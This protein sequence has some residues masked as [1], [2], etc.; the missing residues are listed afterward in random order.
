[1]KSDLS[2][3]HRWARDRRQLLKAGRELTVWNRTPEKVK[4]LLR[5]Q[6]HEAPDIPADGHYGDSA[7][8]S[9]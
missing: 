6:W 8:N 5:A 7:Q 4:D 3:L 2:A 1:M 9:S